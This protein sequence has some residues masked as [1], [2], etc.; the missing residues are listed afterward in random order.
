M[1]SIPTDNSD[2]AGFIKAKAAEIKS[3]R[4]MGTW[5]PVE[6]LSEEQMN[7]SKISMSRCVITKKYHPNGIFDKYKCR[8]VFRGDR[9]YDLT[10]IGHTLALLCPKQYD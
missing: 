8:V 4:D 6:V 10:T 9:W 5:D 7:I 1:L 3:F 2:R